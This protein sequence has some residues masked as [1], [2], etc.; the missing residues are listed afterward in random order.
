MRR[1]KKLPPQAGFDLQTVHTLATTDLEL[2]VKF[3]FKVWDPPNFC[4][5]CF[6]VDFF[7]KRNASISFKTFE[8]I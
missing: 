4:V 1:A 6:S 8:T 7:C 2:N 3:R 5:L